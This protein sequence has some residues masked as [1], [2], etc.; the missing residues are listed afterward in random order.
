[1]HIHAGREFARTPILENCVFFLSS[2][3]SYCGYVILAS[4]AQELLDEEEQHATECKAKHGSD[5]EHRPA[6]LSAVELSY[7]W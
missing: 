2:S 5:G 1:M 7:G 4:S 6:G 3:C